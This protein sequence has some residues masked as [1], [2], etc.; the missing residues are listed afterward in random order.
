MSAPG[1]FFRRI[2]IRRIPIRRI[3]ILC[4]LVAS[5]ALAGGCTSHQPPQRTGSR[6][7]LAGS[8]ER[9]NKTAP[10]SPRTTEA[11]AAPSASL[12]ALPTWLP[13][14][15][16][17]QAGRLARGSDPA[18]LPGPVLI[19]DRD[20]NRLVVVD[21][22]GRVVWQW[23]KPGDLAPGQSFVVPDDAFFTPDG[24]HIIVTQEDDFVITEIDIATRKIGWRYGQPGAHGSGRGLLWN[25][26]D[27]MMLTDGAVIAADIKN[28]RLVELW[29]GASAPVWTAGVPGRCEHAPPFR[30]GSPN[31]AFPMPNGHLLIT[32]INGDWVDEIDSGGHVYWTAHPPGV[33]YPSDTSELAPGK[34][35]TADYS[36]PGQVV[37]FDSSG[38]TLWRWD[39]RTGPGRLDHP[40]LAEGLP[41]GDILLNDDRN[42]R[43]IVIDPNT[44]TI[45]WQYGHT[46]V[47]GA[48]PGYLN[49]PDGLDL[50]PPHSYADHVM[51]G[52]Q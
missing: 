2:S 33:A 24:K 31:G 30:F 20:N 11:S 3:P 25:P 6:V 34:Y 15:L 19:A 26:D 43:V 44:N 1:T 5:A 47:P 48:L 51:A 8:P 14:P 38:H 36:S 50:V 23:P 4:A 35:V 32:E 12:S 46:G 7:A 22:R 18:A 27:A 45:V 17:G 10:E 40:S 28:C 52:S 21:P 39:P 13:A 9:A 41:N 42:H 29:V 16:S 37:V 49:N